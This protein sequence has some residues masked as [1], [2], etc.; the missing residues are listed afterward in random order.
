[1]RLCLLTAGLALGLHFPSSAQAATERFVPP[2]RAPDQPGGRARTIDGDTFDY[3]GERIRIADIDAPELRGQ[4]LAE[5]ALAVR[6]T[7]RTRNL[8][9]SGRI[10]FRLAADGRDRDRFG[11]QLRIVTR[12]GHSIGETL[13]AEGLARRW[14]G[15]RMPWC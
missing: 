3:D 13:I 4:C 14:G 15:R 2:M 12:N 11:R 9:G 5:R 1:M 10:R 6:A 8:L 7:A